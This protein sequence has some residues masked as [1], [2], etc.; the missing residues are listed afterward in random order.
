MPKSRVYWRTRLLFRVRTCG[1]TAAAGLPPR[2]GKASPSACWP[3]AWQDEEAAARKL[4][5]AHGFDEIALP[6]LP[7]TVRDHMRE[8]REDMVTL[9]GRIREVRAKVEK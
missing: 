5:A 6:E 3:P 7:G 9:D 2:P 4:L 8:L 1:R